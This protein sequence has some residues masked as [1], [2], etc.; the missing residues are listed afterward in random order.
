MTLLDAFP[1]VSNTF[2]RPTCE[3][4]APTGSGGPPA[5]GPA[6]GAVHLP[7]TPCA[8]SLARLVDPV[9]ALVGAGL[10]GTLSAGTPMCI[11]P[12]KS[13]PSGP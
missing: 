7:A 4:G 3:T 6:T 2:R 1:N 10:V 13:L 9:T 8:Y 11:H 12:P 5:Y